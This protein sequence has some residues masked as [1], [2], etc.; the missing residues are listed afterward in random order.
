ML[1]CPNSDGICAE[2]ITPLPRTA[3]YIADVNRK[4]HSDRIAI[5]RRI[6]S[7][8]G[9]KGFD[10]VFAPDYKKGS[11]ILCKICKLIQQVPLGY[12]IYD[13]NARRQA[14]PNLFYEASLMHYLGK[15]VIMIGFKERRPSDL[16]SIEWIHYENTSQVIKDFEERLKA[17][18]DVA[19][20]T[21]FADIEINAGNYLI[22]I[23]YL[24]KVLLI[25]PN[26]NTLENLNSTN[27]L[28]EQMPVLSQEYKRNIHFINSI[29]SWLSTH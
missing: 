6:K 4:P 17:V 19:V 7:I 10:V 11:N 16:E 22:G 28:L 3:L 29:D 18:L 5:E 23:E 14:V 27:K 21:S 12:L 25:S 20:F 15:D 8:L 2:L 1:W 13:R 26:R 24:K 9:K